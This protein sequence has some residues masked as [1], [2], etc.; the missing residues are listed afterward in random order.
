MITW[1]QE[2]VN[3][4]YKL[5]TCVLI[6]RLFKWKMLKQLNSIKDVETRYDT[7]DNET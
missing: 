4:I 2:G 6:V 7:P 1:F 3:K 5:V